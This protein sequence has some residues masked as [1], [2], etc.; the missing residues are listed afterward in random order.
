[1]QYCSSCLHVGQTPWHSSLSGSKKCF[2]FRDMASL[3]QESPGLVGEKAFQVGNGF[4]P[5]VLIGTVLVVIA[6]GLRI[7][8]ATLVGKHANVATVVVRIAFPMPT[9]RTT[10]HGQTPIK[11]FG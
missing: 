9:V 1:M 3:P 2:L 11:V 6:P 5:C 7:A 8:L 10:I 4:V